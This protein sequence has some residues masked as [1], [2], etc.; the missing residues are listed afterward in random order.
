MVALMF[1]RVSDYARLGCTSQEG[2]PSRPVCTILTFLGDWDSRLAF[3]AR[4][5]SPSHD[6]TNFDLFE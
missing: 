4:L 6:T 2:Y 5:K 1:G 3:E